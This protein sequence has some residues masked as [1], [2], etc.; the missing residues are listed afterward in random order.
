MNFFVQL[1]VVLFIFLGSKLWKKSYGDTVLG[2]DISPLKPDILLLRCQH[3][4]L[5][6]EFTIDKCPKSNGKKFYMINGG[7]GL[8]GG[9]AGQKKSKSKLRK[10]VNISIYSDP[11]KYDSS[12]M[13]SN[14]YYSV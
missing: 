8:D 3:S 2:F 13:S 9:G 10:M 7:N 6:T 14:A 12:H 1:N 4:F 5:L 11:V